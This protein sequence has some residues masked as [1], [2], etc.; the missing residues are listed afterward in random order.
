MDDELAECFVPLHILRPGL[1][2]FPMR[3]PATGQTLEGC[4]VLAFVSFHTDMQSHAATRTTTLVSAQPLSDLV[5][6]QAVR[7]PINARLDPTSPTPTRVNLLGCFIEQGGIS[8][9]VI[10]PLDAYRF[11]CTLLFWPRLVRLDRFTKKIILC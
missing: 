9:V 4:F 2:C 3:S 1:R 6:L 10:I 7:T 8:M 11:F 5:W